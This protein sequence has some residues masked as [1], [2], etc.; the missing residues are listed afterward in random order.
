MKLRLKVSTASRLGFWAGVAVGIVPLPLAVIGLV[1]S[2]SSAVLVVLTYIPGFAVAVYVAEA[3]I[4]GLCF[5]LARLRP[6]GKGILT[7]L[8]ITT[9]GWHVTYLLLPLFLLS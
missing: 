8:L 6:L 2:P 3:A 1:N 7:G 9:I 4:A 5:F